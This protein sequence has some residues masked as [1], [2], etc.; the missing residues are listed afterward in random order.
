[1]GLC[2]CWRVLLTVCHRGGLGSASAQFIEICVVQGGT[3]TGF[4]P[5]TSVSPVINIPPVLYTHLHLHVALTRR[6]HW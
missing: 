4:S 6:T 2:Y 1:M 5:S 3:G